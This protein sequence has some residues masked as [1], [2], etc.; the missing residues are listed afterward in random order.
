MSFKEQ[1]FGMGVLLTKFEEHRLTDRQ[2]I[3][4]LMFHTNVSKFSGE[5]R[6]GFTDKCMGKWK[7]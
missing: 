7:P 4:L 1:I 5:L 6:L 2:V 3:L